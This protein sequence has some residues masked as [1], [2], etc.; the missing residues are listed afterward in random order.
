MPEKFIREQARSHRIYVG[1]KN[2]MWERNAVHSSD[3]HTFCG[4]GFIPS[5]QNAV[6]LKI[7]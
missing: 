2:P 6:C 5:P 1:T 4:E 7:V 3:T